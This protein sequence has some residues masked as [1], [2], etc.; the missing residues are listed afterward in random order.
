MEKNYKLSFNAKDCLN[1]IKEKIKHA[2][3]SIDIEI[4]YFT[5]DSVGS[6][7]L[8]LLYHPCS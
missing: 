6:D 4:F 7:F 2:K 5:E 3:I 8:I 1:S